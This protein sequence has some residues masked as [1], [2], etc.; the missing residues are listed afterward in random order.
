MEDKNQAS[1]REKNGTVQ[2]SI[3]SVKSQP[4]GNGEVQT[5]ISTT[6]SVKSQPEG[7][8]VLKS[9]TVSV[10]QSSK[11]DRDGK[12]QITSGRS[13]NS[14]SRGSRT[15]SFSSLFGSSVWQKAEL[16]LKDTVLSYCY[17]AQGQRATLEILL[18]DLVGIE[19][20]QSPPP[21]YENACEF[22][23]HIFPLITKMFARRKVRQQLKITIH[24]DVYESFKDNL[25]AAHEWKTAVLLQAQRAMKVIFEQV[26]DKTSCRNSLEGVYYGLPLI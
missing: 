7:E 8:T 17:E 2:T 21:N 9:I 26:E 18:E 11:V 10:P 5:S 13:R 14:S 12:I 4:E 6:S 1:S 23:I 15:G 16:S 19:V 25:S 22:L 24:F 20:L 3:S